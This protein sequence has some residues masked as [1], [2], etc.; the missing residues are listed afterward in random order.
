[1]WDVRNRPLRGDKSVFR[2]E[3]VG[4]NVVFT[5]VKGATEITPVIEGTYL[6]DENAALAAA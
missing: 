1:M 3:D 5:C 4:D 2:L 6:K